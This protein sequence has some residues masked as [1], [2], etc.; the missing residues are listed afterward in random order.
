MQRHEYFE[1]LCSLAVIGELSAEEWEQLSSHLRECRECQNTVRELN[2][3]SSEQLPLAS[4]HGGGKGKLA[5]DKVREETVQRL[6]R[7][8]LRISPEAAQGGRSLGQRWRTGIGEFQ[9][10]LLARRAQIAAVVSALVV[11][12]VFAVMLRHD[13]AQQRQVQVLQKQVRRTPV[14]I[15]LERP[16][17]EAVTRRDGTEDRASD[18]SRSLAEANLKIERLQSER[19]EAQETIASLREDV[20]RVSSENARLQESAAAGQTQLADLRGQIEQFRNKLNATDAELVATRY[21]VTSLTAELKTD[22]TALE[23]EKELLAAGRDVRDVMAARNLHIIDVH[24]TDAHGEARPFGRIFLT[25][26]K[27]LI[28]YAYDLDTDKMKNAAFQ[29]WG[30]RTDANRTAVNLGILYMD[31]QKQSR[32][33]LKVENADLLKTIDSLFV[34]VEPQGGVPKP[35][36]KKLMYAYL[37]NPINHP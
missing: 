22:Q 35:T 9:W 19:T 34:T 13:R 12:C 11:T 26:G 28:F 1:Q 7:E 31:D 32:W 14:A 25:E 37:R 2:V 8:G 23:H 18:L 21:Q 15:P 17:T 10:L 36:G 4:A 3:I 29:A 30:Q 5:L 24:D 16:R 6:M 33:A 20:T 27:R